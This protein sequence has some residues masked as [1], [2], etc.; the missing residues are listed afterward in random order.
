[1]SVTA[2]VGSES[3]SLS[4]GNPFWLAGYVGLGMAPLHVITSRG[5]E[6][7]GE[8]RV[9][10]RLDP[11]AFSLVLGMAPDT[12]S[13]LQTYKDQ[14]TA[15]LTPWG[16]GLLLEWLLANGATR[17][18]TCMRCGDGDMSSAD[19]QGF[20]QRAAVEFHAGDPTF[21]DPVAG[22]QTFDLGGAADG[23]A[24][25]TA[26]PTAIGASTIDQTHLVTYPGSAPSSPVV[27]IVGPI[28]N[29]IIT[30]VTT[31]KVL[32]FTG[33]TVAAADWYDTDTR[34]GQQTVVDAAG[35]S[36]IAKLTDASDLGTF[37][38]AP[39]PVAA[40]GVN[41]IRV[42]GSAITAATQVIVTW[43]NRYLGI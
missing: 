37:A 5:P 21:Y 13:D 38:L 33:Y 14:L 24:V 10:F 25:P 1:M 19:K 18:I 3:L 17:R 6:Q 11:R 35:A 9:D 23:F 36:Q 29:P 8:T 32:S 7:H 20:M 27:R 39:W 31:G 43:W 15:F 41:A 16:D 2:W 28:T 22:A 40:G 26:V 34:Y 42:T 30:N 12:A 4:D